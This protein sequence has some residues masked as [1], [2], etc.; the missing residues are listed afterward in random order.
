MDLQAS[1]L[2]G[3]LL[4]SGA[5]FLYAFTGVMALTPFLDKG[6]GS[7]VKEHQ[8]V[9]RD[10]PGSGTAG[11]TRSKQYA[12]SHCQEWST[13][14]RFNVSNRKSWDMTTSLPKLR[15]KQETSLSGM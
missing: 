11:E 4:D 10:S 8:S 13:I 3:E 15:E 7:Q 5:F 12:E 6:G 1:G 14:E 2:K 9:R